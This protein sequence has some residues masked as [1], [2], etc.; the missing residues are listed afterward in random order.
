MFVIFHYEIL[1]L[2]LPGV[3]DTCLARIL[4]VLFKGNNVDMFIR[5][6]SAVSVMDV[7]VTITLFF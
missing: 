7:N 6:E 4:S 5:K 2:S 1:I 3:G